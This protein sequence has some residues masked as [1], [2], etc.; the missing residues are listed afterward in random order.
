MK[1]IWMK[2]WPFL[3]TICFWVV[4]VALILQC[5][6]TGHIKEVKTIIQRDTLLDTIMVTETEYDTAYFVKYVQ[7]HPQPAGDT[8][9]IP[10]TLGNPDTTILIAED[11][12]LQVP[13]TQKVYRD[14]DYTAWVS[15]YQAQLDSMQ[16]YRRTISETITNTITIR[17]KASRWAL[18]ATAGVGYGV[19]TMKPD[20]FVGVGV[21]YRI[22]P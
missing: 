2:F 5:S 7:V 10:E 14:S 19:T 18:G 22:L 16:I 21:T 11:G 4:A 13:I 9:S 1:N 17:K 12:T 3:V 20:V 8:V 15:G 6:D